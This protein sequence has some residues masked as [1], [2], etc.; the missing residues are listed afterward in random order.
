MP[1][2]LVLQKA[3]NENRIILTFD[4]DFAA[5]I[6][7]SNASAPSVIILRLKNQTP[8]NQINKINHVL[9][10]AP[11]SLLKGAIV[12]VDETSFRIK[13]LPVQNIT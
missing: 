12:S 11:A 13:H 8:D 4:L 2:E 7:V 1:D 10:K 5:L 3:K 6:A 9:A